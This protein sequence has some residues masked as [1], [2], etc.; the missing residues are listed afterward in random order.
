MVRGRQK[1]LLGQRQAEE[2]AWLETS[3]GGCLGQR[4]AEEA[5][6][7]ATSRGGC[8]GRGRW[9]RL[10]GQ[11]QAEEVTKR[12]GGVDHEDGEGYDDEEERPKAETSVEEAEKLGGRVVKQ[13]NGEE[14]DRQRGK[15]RR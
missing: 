3:R 4:Q 12:L 11:R 5:A 6:W 9:R 15:T 14:R 10:L 2:A 13:E 1:K 8:L 7:S